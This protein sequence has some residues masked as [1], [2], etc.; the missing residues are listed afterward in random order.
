MGWNKWLRKGNS[1]YKK[2]SICPT[3]Q[4]MLLETGFLHQAGVWGYQY[5]EKCGCVVY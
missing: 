2:P 1:I 3:F 4:S 5:E